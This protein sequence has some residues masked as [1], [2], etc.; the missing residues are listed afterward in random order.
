MLPAV[1]DRGAA[2]LRHNR[3]LRSDR[4]R[5]SIVAAEAKPYESSVTATHDSGSLRPER[6]FAGLRRTRLVLVVTAV[7]FAVLWAVGAIAAGPAL[8]GFA[9]VAAAVLIAT[10]KSESSPALLSR[11]E[12]HAPGPREPLR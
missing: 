3:L 1:M 9:L 2:G 6:W 12:P 11:G 5:P 7:T 4:T 10:A 8:A